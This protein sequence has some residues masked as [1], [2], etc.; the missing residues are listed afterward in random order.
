MADAVKISTTLTGPAFD[1]RFPAAIRQAVEDAKLA[2]G[3]FGAGIV[4]QNLSA[5]IRSGTSYVSG[6]RAHRLKT[7]VVKIINLEY[8]QILQGPWLEGD[9]SR[10]SP[11]GFAGYSASRKAVQVVRAAVP[12]LAKPILE[13]ALGGTL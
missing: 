2:V 10:N 4:T 1:D 5:S 11:S 6:V 3:Q 7:G 9:D 8:P 12:R 13:R